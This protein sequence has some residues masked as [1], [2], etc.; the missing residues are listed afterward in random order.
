MLRGFQA[1]DTAGKGGFLLGSVLVVLSSVGFGSTPLMV[2]LAHD[3]G[4]G[5]EAIAFWRSAIPALF[6]F[7]YLFGGTH[8]K[9]LVFSGI[10]C[11]VIMGLGNVAYFKA[12]TQVPVTSAAFIFYAYPVLALLFGW[13]FF[14]QTLTWIHGLS[15]LLILSGVALALGPIT[16]PS[17]LV[18]VLTLALIAPL[19]QGFAI[20]LI[21]G[22]LAPLPISTR[23]GSL[24]L[25]N[26]LAAL[27]FMLLSSSAVLPDGTNGT[28][29][30]A[31]LGLVG[32]LVPAF[33]F[34]AGARMTG[35][36]FAGILSGAEFVVVLA[37]GWLILKEPVLGHQV[38]GALLIIAA[39]LVTGW[40]R[41]TARSQAPDT[42]ISGQFGGNR[43]GSPDQDV[44]LPL[45]VDL[46]PQRLWE[47]AQTRPQ[48]N[49][50]EWG[51][52]DRLRA[53]EALTHDG[54]SLDSVAARYKIDPR[55]LALWKSRLLEYGLTGLAVDEALL[56]PSDVEE[57]E[58]R[59][60][61]LEREVHQRKMENTILRDALSRQH[62]GTQHQGA[63]H[64]GTGTP[65]ANPT[66][67]PP[68]RGR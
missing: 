6:M 2:S 40:P 33:L 61:D 49:P 44:L 8:A 31:A 46:L 21:T 27:P 43:F 15:G 36:A 4:V 28:L 39:S 58:N 1:F 64:L 53:L 11:G 51:L 7:G 3:A 25:G 47:T 68:P 63:R 41:H 59:I 54:E 29:A 12:L 22:V 34:V 23:L 38:A 55:L 37:G 52:E 32:V 24:S 10:A 17:H 14:R 5:A 60:H 45:M 66:K 42:S 57:M 35:P 62:Q 26:M 67:Q 30:L 9:R 18:P 48:R 20:N 16:I 13:L 65:P 50:A 19:A 56:R